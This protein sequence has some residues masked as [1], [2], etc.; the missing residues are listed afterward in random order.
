MRIA[1]AILRRLATG[2]IRSLCAWAESGTMMSV[3][4]V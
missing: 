2:F 1:R 3:G 4:L